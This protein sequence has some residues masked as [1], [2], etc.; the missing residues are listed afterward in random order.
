MRQVGGKILIGDNNGGVG[1]GSHTAAKLNFSR[2]CSSQNIQKSNRPIYL[3]VLRQQRMAHWSYQ[4][5]T[6]HEIDDERTYTFP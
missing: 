4:K 5:G 1:G 2:V 6:E 3:T